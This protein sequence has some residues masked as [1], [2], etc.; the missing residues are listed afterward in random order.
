MQGSI[1]VVRILLK[2]PE[3]GHIQGI[4]FCSGGFSF[5]TVARAQKFPT[6]SY[7]P[8]FLLFLTPKIFAA[9][10]AAFF[11]SQF[12]TKYSFHQK[13]WSS[14]PF[15]SASFLLSERLRRSKT[16]FSYLSAPAALK[17]LLFFRAPTAPNFLLFARNFL[18]FRATARHEKKNYTWN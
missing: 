4:V 9:L 12:H 13:C 1:S 6:F 3:K 15:L 7:L 18:L 17:I 8:Y 11:P 16:L 10:R 14:A 5:P 2:K